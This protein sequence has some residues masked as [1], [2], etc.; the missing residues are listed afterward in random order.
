MESVVLMFLCL[1]IVCFPF[2][3]AATNVSLSLLLA[4]GLLT[5]F[6]WQGARILWHQHR[7]LTLAL[8]TYLALVLIGL[9]WSIDPAWGMKILGRH[10]FWLLLPVVVMTLSTRQNRQIFLA[11][12]SFGLTANLV[13]CV[14]QANGLI[15]S[16]AAA[17]SSATNATGH[18]GHTS[19]G[20]IYGIWSAWLVHWGLLHRGRQAWA[21]WGLAV[22]AI[23]MVFMAQGQSGYIVTV[24]LLLLVAVKWMQRFKVK[25]MVMAGF[26]FL[27]IAGTVISFGPAKERIT[28]TWDALTQLDHQRTGNA[29]QTGAIASA[30]A[31][32][33][34]WSMSI[35]I[36]RQGAFF[37]VGTGGFPKAVMNWQR[38]P[39]LQRGYI[40][41]YSQIAIVHPHN[42]YFITLVRYG[43][44]GLLLF[45][46]MMV[47]WTAKGMNRQWHDSSVSPLI[48][49]TGVALLLHGLDSTS[50]EEHFSSIFALILLGAGLSE[51]YLKTLATDY[52]NEH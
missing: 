38:H 2:S 14:L 6:W 8:A 5:G 37:G 20:F 43:V 42:Q 31:R 33:A 21:A 25:N 24:A 30:Q 39:A 40:N 47:V 22:W 18:I 19:F 17:G 1:A 32:L 49:L 4:S 41:A 50:L 48:A 13:F 44:P 26:V 51:N 3:V 28:G 34:W 29:V 35:D 46:V 52:T 27:L 10:W 23:V 15:D 45:L 7:L 16:H 12:M 9:T 36:W 11:M